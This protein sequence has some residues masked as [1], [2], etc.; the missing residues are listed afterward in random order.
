MDM[1]IAIG[2]I[3]IL[4]L[5]FIWVSGFLIGKL[6]LEHEI[7]SIKDIIEDQSDVHNKLLIEIMEV[8]LE[9]AK[10][11]EKLLNLWEYVKVDEEMLDEIDEI[12]DEIKDG[13]IKIKK[14]E[15]Q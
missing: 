10:F 1:I 15:G 13:I 9:N 6:V 12:E 3:I 14:K 4:I 11:Q 7:E 5:V 2:L 8:R